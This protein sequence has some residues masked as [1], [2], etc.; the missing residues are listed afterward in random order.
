MNG[1]VPIL[2]SVGAA[3]RFVRENLNFILMAS[4]AGALATAILSGLALTSPV[5]GV[6]A[7]VGSTFVQATVY[8]LFTTA[9]LIGATAARGRMMGDG[10]RVWAAM[11]VIG[12]FMFIVM[13]IVTI[14]VLIVLFAGPLAP[15]VDDLQAAQ[16]DQAAVM[17]VMNTFA[18]ANPGAVLA[19]MLFYTAL[20][21]LL[22]SRLYLAAPASVEQG[23]ILTFE[24]WRWTKGA[25]LR[26]TAARLLL[27]LPANVLAFAVGYLAG[28]LVGVDALN[29]PDAAASN[30]AG[31][32]AYVAAAAFITFAL[33]SSLEAGLSSYMYRGLKPAETP[34][35]A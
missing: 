17:Q 8:A 22:T 24:T 19:T 34:K 30:P 12:F 4:G 7:G 16:G 11:F 3:M 18:Q 32:L 26:I 10:W 2:E 23:R 1:N 14:P 25:T 33:Y 5:I 31:Y 20:W 21:L 13:F 27:L 28:R 9:C 29:R 6:F 35:P 15:Y